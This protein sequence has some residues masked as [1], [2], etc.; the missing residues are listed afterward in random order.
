MGSSPGTPSLSSPSSTVSPW[1][2]GHKFS[3]LSIFS[4]N[5]Q[6]RAIHRYLD[7]KQ[8]LFHCQH[9]LVECGQAKLGIQNRCGGAHHMLG[10]SPAMPIFC[11]LPSTM[12]PWLGSWRGLEC[13]GI[14]LYG[15]FEDLERAGW[16]KW[17]S[18]HQL[19]WFKN[20]WSRN[21]HV[22]DTIK[23]TLGFESISQNFIREFLKIHKSEDF[24]R[25][26]CLKV[27][28]FHHLVFLLYHHVHYLP[29]GNRHEKLFLCDK[30]LYQNSMR[31]VWMRICPSQTK[32]LWGISFLASLVA[33]HFTPVSEWV[34]V[35]N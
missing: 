27:W 19:S 23:E 6:T 1:A 32:I 15:A 3:C 21:F 11:L 33:L 8:R 34:V 2:E 24:G 7:G 9:L 4:D 26:A 35:S 22:F 29:M 17:H 14:H 10:P 28:C 18:S 12:A 25:K 30:A 13:G 31:P 5:V 16:L 20:N